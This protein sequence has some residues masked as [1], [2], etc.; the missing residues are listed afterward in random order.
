LNDLVVARGNLSIA[1]KL[2]IFINNKYFTKAVGDGL[3][4]STPTGS[5][6]YGLAA[7]GPIIH[8]EVKSITLVPISPHSLSF[9]PIVF[10]SNVRICITVILI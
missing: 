2:D 7:G 9:R 8:N 3:I 4:L 5:T 6:A 10:P 1:T